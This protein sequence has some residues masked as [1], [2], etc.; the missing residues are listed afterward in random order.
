MKKLIA[1]LI[2]ALTF[3]TLFFA[4]MAAEPKYPVSAIPEDMKQGMYAVVRESESRF[5]IESPG[6]SVHYERLLLQS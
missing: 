6:N 1:G 4:A 3:Q 5:Y 2:L